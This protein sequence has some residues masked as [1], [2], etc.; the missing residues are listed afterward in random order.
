MGTKSGGGGEDMAGGG[1]AEEGG[2]EKCLSGDLL[3]RGAVC[4][5]VSL[6]RQHEHE[7]LEQVQLEVALE[8]LAA[9]LVEEQA[10]RP[11]Q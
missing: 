3:E 4:L 2:G 9:K 5:P 10:K 1:A 11:R 7:Q 8:R 6:C